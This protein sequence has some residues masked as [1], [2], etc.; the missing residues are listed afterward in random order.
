MIEKFI[1]EDK[2]LKRKMMNCHCHYVLRQEMEN[3]IG[4]QDY[5]L[6]T[7]YGTFLKFSTPVQCQ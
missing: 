5:T 3:V 4:L 2:V 7:C 1:H 6:A